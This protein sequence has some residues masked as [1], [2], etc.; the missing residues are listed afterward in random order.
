MGYDARRR[1]QML[2]LNSGQAWH[3][4]SLQDFDI[5]LTKSHQAVAT[6]HCRRHGDHFSFW[7]L[8]ALPQM[9][10][11]LP[12][13]EGVWEVPGTSGTLR[14]FSTRLLCAQV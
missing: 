10:S 6:G 4:G 2:C 8:L 3:L 9:W 1:F 13:G 12:N 11:R 14:P 5:N 7:A